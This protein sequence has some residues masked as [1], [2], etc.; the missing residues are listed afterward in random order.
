MPQ[1]KIHLLGLPYIEFDNEE[2]DLSRRKALALLAYLAI[3]GKQHSRDFISATLW[4]DYEPD[5]ARAELRRIL[6]TINKTT[7]RQVDDY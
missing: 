6:N 1:L 3:T 2:I 7:R 4:S 5:R